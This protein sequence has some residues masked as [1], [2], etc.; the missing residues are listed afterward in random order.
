VSDLDDIRDGLLGLH[1]KAGQWPELETEIA[2]LHAKAVLTKEPEAVLAEPAES[3]PEAD[4]VPVA[5][6]KA[7]GVAPDDTVTMADQKAGV[8]APAAAWDS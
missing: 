4:L 7:A 8:P 1:A 3:G 6:Q 2:L 5:D